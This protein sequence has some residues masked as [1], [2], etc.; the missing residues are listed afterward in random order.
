[1][2]A[3]TAPGIRRSKDIL[4]TFE[5]I[6]KIVCD[7]LD[8]DYTQVFGKSRNRNLVEARQ[9]IMLLCKRETTLTLKNIG[10]LMNGLDHTTVMHGYK[11]M[12][13]LI[14]TDLLIKDKWDYFQSIMQQRYKNRFA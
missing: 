6:T 14:E 5:Q 11:T 1:M 3:Y 8:V 13:D 12:Q 9:F 2:T 10:L 7:Y 4:P